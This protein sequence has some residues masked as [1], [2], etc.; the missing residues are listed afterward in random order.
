MQR[1]I[2][3]GN[4]TN[5]LRYLRD[6]AVPVGDNL[7]RHELEQPTPDIE[8]ATAYFLQGRND[9]KDVPK[10]IS[11]FR[12]FRGVPFV[13]RAV[14]IW[15]D[16]GFL[17]EHL[18]EVGAEAHQRISTGKMT[19]EEKQQTLL[20]IADLNDQ[21][22]GLENDFSRTLGEG[23]NLTSDLLFFLMVAIAVSVLAIGF[24]LSR[25]LGQSI[26]RETGEF[27]AQSGGR[28]VGD[29]A[30]HSDIDSAHEFGELA[31]RFNTMAAG[32]ER[33]QQ[34]FERAQ[35]AT[36][37]SLGMRWRFLANLTGRIRTPL[38]VVLGH[39]DAITRQLGENSDS[40][41]TTHL[42]GIRAAGNRLLVTVQRVLDYSRIEAGA[43]ELRP[44]ALDLGTILARNV[45]NFQADSGRKG[46]ELDCR[47]EESAKATIMIDEYCLSEALANL[48]SNAIKFT[49]HGAVAARLFRA[50][51]ALR[52]EVQDTGVGIEPSYLPHLFEPFSG[53]DSVNGGRFEGVGLGLALTRG[54]LQLNRAGLSV[55]SA[56][57]KGSAFII[58]F[59]PD[60]EVSAAE[61]PS[62]PRLVR[63]SRNTPKSS[64]SN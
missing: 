62:R 8:K 4:E 7:A 29:F 11:L 15:S 63:L 40:R 16:A 31:K 1:Y 48:L 35:T 64:D 44:A 27:S 28:I 32:I 49:E 19:P 56:V 41:L 10:L 24:L 9:P 36:A 23:F 53:P 54:Y 55:Q 38:T 46:I 18:V 52:I 43:F 12:R 14:Q 3:G 5:Y 20:R 51:G 22:I 39:T 47:I 57:G 6:I 26:R 60:C 25:A 17:I 37:R 21:L 13:E 2:E 34:E 61:E 59:P 42:N 45:R 50:D 33:A 30:A 58:E